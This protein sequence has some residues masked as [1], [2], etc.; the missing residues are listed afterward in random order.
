METYKQLSVFLENE[1]GTLARVCDALFDAKINILA[2]NVHDS[3]DYSIFRCVVT[4]PLKA[5]HL[6]ESAGVF[7]LEDEVLGIPLDNRPGALGAIAR[8][9][10]KARINIDYSYGSAPRSRGGSSLLILK[11]N[12]IGKTKKILE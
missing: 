6:L 9:L 12:N 2:H 7:V 10:A 8:K 4:D 11:T 1:P 3:I 5:V